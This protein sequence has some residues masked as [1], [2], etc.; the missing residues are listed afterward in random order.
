M[1]LN[2]PI[3]IFDSGLGGLTV[4]KKILE[5]LP[6]ESTL[7]L[8]DEIHVPYGERD[9]AEIR[10]LALGI[11]NFLEQH[12]SK[13]IVMACNVST[14]T[15]LEAARATFPNVP[16]VGMIE[17]GAR[18][19]LKIAT[20]SS[21]GV[22]ATT[23]TV[24][25]RAYTRAI[26]GTAPEMR[27]VERAC[28]SFVPIVESGR[29]DSLDA[30]AAVREHVTPLLEDGCTTLILGCTHYPYLRKIIED[31]AGEGI[32]VVDP[33]EEVA[34]EAAKI[35]LERGELNPE[36]VEP[37]HSYYTTASP[38]SFVQHGSRF[39]AGE[40]FCAERIFWGVDL[41]IMRCQEKT[42]EA[43][44]RSEKQELLVDI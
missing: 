18:A 8:G 5:R 34:N 19:A 31:V 40:H 21:I 26:Q 36:H 22:L 27:V 17:A 25:T 32:S 33:S 23:G 44:T 16:I 39:L 41:R 15:A 29:W 28:P 7:Y 11:C 6:G 43:M 2:A 30:V 37:V 20:G 4:V 14:A 42:D 9:A 38:K 24:K 3:G 12:R 35:L 10:S 13:L 1:R